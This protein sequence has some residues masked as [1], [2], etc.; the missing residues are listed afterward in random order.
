MQ[1]LFLF[2]SAMAECVMAALTELLGRHGVP[3]QLLTDRGS[4]FMSEEFEKFLHKLDIE[5]LCTIIY[6]PQ[7]NATCERFHGTL[8]TMMRALV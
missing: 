3:K 7:S 6:H 8:K 4:T 5:H 2:P 1:K